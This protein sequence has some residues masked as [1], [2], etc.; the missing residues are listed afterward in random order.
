MYELFLVGLLFCAQHI[1][2]AYAAIEI[3][4]LDYRTYLIVT[5]GISLVLA[6]VLKVLMFEWKGRI[7]QAMRGEWDDG[8]LLPDVGLFLITMIAGGAVSAY[9]VYRRYGITGWMG[10][11]AA[12]YAVGWIV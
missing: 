3:W 2:I 8:E 5:T 4:R 6:L 1:A 11:L 7:V 10:A 9:L 12:N